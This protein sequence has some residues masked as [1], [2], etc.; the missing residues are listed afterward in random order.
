MHTGPTG[1]TT[2]YLETGKKRVFA[3]A[4]Q[5]PGW[6]PSGRTEDH[7]PSELARSKTGP[8]PTQDQHYPF[9]VWK[10]LVSTLR[11]TWT[12]DKSGAN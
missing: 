12:S 7:A 11:L 1:R 9:S 8:T 4:L 3:C 10:S 6:C 5:W 2:V